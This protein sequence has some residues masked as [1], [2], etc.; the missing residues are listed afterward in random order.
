[1]KQ[2]SEMTALALASMLLAQSC[3]TTGAQKPGAED[4]TT[5][6]EVERLLDQLTTNKKMRT[7]ARDAIV[8]MGPS[9]TPALISQFRSPH[10]TIRW[11]IANILWTTTN[12]LLQREAIPAHRALMRKGIDDIFRDNLE[13]VIRG[14]QAG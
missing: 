7:S 9:A 5:Q 2:P 8:A 6:R 11:E 4:A 13:L 1:M 12:G 14:L 3:A 10:F